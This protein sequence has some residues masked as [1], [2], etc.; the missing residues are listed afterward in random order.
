M[1]DMEFKAKK[2]APLLEVLEELFPKSSKNRL[3]RWIKDGRIR[4]EKREIRDQNFPISKKMSLTLRNKTKHAPYGI[5]ILYEDRDLV[6]LEKPPSLLSVATHFEEKET[7][8]AVLKMGYRYQRVFPVHR[9]DRETSGVMVFAYSNRA[10]EDL[11]RQFYS[12]LIE[13]GYLAIVEGHLETK[14][15]K[16][17][18]TLKENGNYFVSSH[19]RGKIAITHYEVVRTTNHFTSL[20][21]RL[22]TGRKNQIRAQA[23]EAGFPVAGDLKYG[24]KKN[25]LK[26]LA[27]HAHYLSF[28]HP[29]MKK[30]MVF[31]SPPPPPFNHLF[32]SVE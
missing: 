4:V 3:K 8:H 29:I 1:I 13:R 28:T 18:S 17:E 24:S 32:R 6:V 23:S 25:P 19:P 12:H 2:S 7:V 26:R 5:K 11:K 31:N 27:L 22:E 10:K 16:W 30:K 15:G 20:K 21:L 14:K 9:L